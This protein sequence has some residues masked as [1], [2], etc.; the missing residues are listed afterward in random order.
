ME[1]QEK[2]QEV[3]YD[4]V[5]DFLNSAANIIAE[6]NKI[7]KE[8]KTEEPVVQNKEPKGSFSYEEICEL[9]IQEAHKTNKENPDFDFRNL[10][11]KG[12]KIFY[13]LITDSYV[14]RKEMISLTV[15]TVYPR[16]IVGVE[17][18]SQCQCIGYKQKDNI[19]INRVDANTY[20]DSLNEYIN[21]EELV[22]DTTKEE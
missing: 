7:I 9:E 12:D 20:F 6:N 13:V 18:G 8:N 14:K 16:M 2:A 15:R 17:E 4:Q 5:D 10:Y 22:T 21:D 11:S 3:T 19:F 1:E